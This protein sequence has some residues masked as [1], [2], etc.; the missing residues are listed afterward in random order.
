LLTSSARDGQIVTESSGYCNRE[1]LAEFVDF[2]ML[3]C[4]ARGPR[5]RGRVD[6]KINLGESPR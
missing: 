5:Q 1:S 6:H 4:P 2:D 3:I